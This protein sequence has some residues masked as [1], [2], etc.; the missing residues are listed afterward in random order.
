VLSEK[1]VL[2][3]REIQFPETTKNP[4]GGQGIGWFV[5]RQGPFEVISH[6]GGTFG[7]GSQFMVLPEQGVSISVLTNG[8]GG[9]A[10]IGGVVK[11][12]FSRLGGVEFA[13]EIAKKQAAAAEQDTPA[14]A[15]AGEDLDLQKY[16][17]V[18]ERKYLTTTV[19]LD[20]GALKAET[21]MGG[22][23]TGKMAPPP[24]MTLKPVDTT[25][26]LALDDEGKPTSQVKFSELDGEGRPEYLI[27][28]R[29]SRRVS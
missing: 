2:A 17:G 8:P 6:G 1:S 11:E 7:Q 25:T 10:V 29:V 12:V 28:G 27:M 19:T 3:M 20:E 18:Y 24:V 14:E 4:A 26:F 21:V 16:V 13:A 15:P 9:G 5:G 23:L 22:Y